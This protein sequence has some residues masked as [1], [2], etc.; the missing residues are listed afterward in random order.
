[1]LPIAAGRLFDVTQS[2]RTAV[3]ISAG[4]NVLGILIALGLPR[5]GASRPAERSAE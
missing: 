1:V 4:G 5:Q 2:Y 3:M